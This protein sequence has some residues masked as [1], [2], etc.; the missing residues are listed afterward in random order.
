MITKTVN[1]DSA[2][3]SLFDEIRDK[4]QG[5]IDIHNIEGFFGNIQEIASLNEKYLRLPLDEP[6]FE[7]DANTRKIEV[8]TDFRSN[9]ISV[10][11]DHLAETVFFCIDRYFDYTDLGGTD[12][13][14]NWKM[15]NDSGRTKHF[16]LNKD[17]VPGSIVF[18]WPIDKIVTAKSGTLSFA[19]EFNK[20]NNEGVTYRFNTLVANVNI[21]DGLIIDENV[22][23]S[24][25]DRSIISSLTNSSFTSEGEAAVGD[26]RWLTGDGH[27][28][29][30]GAG[31]VGPGGVISSFNPAE[32]QESLN[33]RTL[34]SA[35]GVPSSISIYLLAQAYVDRQTRIH[36]TDNDGNFMERRYLQVSSTRQLVEDRDNLDESLVYYT[37]NGPSAQ[38]ATAEDLENDSI[39]L[40]AV[41][42]LN[43]DLMYYTQISDS[44]PVAYELASDEAIAAWGTE[45]Q[46]PLY[47]EMAAL[48]VTEAGS[49]VI[50]AQGEKWIKV[51][52]EE[53][54]EMIDKKIGAGDIKRTD[55]VTVPAAKGPESI[56]I[57]GLE[58]ENFD[59]TSENYSI[60]ESAENVI[61]TPDEGRDIKAVAVFENLG[62]SQIVWQKGTERNGV[63]SYE[64]ASAE[65]TPFVLAA[66]ESV[67][68][69]ATEGIYRVGVTNFIN[70]TTSNVVYS[71]PYTVS[72]L[73]TPIETADIEYKQYTQT[74]PQG[75]WLTLYQGGSVN[76]R[77]NDNSMTR[78]KATVRINVTEELT[79][80]TE[81]R[82]EWYRTSM[83]IDVVPAAE[84]VWEPMGNEAELTTDV[85]GAYKPV[86][87]NVYNGSIYTKELNPFYINSL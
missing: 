23:V 13:F 50:K 62:A 14:I 33:L 59:P 63:I 2:Y 11:G 79:N 6:M 48:Q 3:D 83:D 86:V 12:I 31:P 49:Y 58:I 65:E 61:F 55:I 52:N 71:A 44:D 76:F 29:I 18:G 56:E 45:E 40:Y 38:V 80:S 57:E 10:Q 1:L 5:Q 87:K 24:S 51:E 42:P 35:Q 21:R 20:T 8:P 39:D 77:P 54:G 4:S 19:V 74:N 25:L 84:I 47:A 66:N 64:N 53:T 36:Y 60:D 82:F 27:G 72:K 73:A 41:A 34:V 46:V 9:G 85:E 68:E 32:W 22:Q 69:D 67:F 75:Q 81:L 43:P 37:G 30:S 78:R 15:G 16:I 28:L 26:V 17:I 7:I 70:A